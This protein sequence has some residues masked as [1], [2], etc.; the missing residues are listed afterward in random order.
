M[1]C[2]N[3]V[4]THPQGEKAA[5]SGGGID[6]KNAADFLLGQHTTRLDKGNN[7]KASIE[8]NVRLLPCRNGGASFGKVETIR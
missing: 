5:T 2:K 3:A 6:P 7:T 4:Y 1:D 8:D